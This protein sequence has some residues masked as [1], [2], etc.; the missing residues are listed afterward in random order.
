MEMPDMEDEA[1][2]RPF[3]FIVTGQYLAIHY[4]GGNFEIC[5]D[6]HTRGALFYLSYD[7][8]QIIHDRTYVA[9]LTDY[10]DYEG[11]VFYISKESQYLS[12]NG[13][14]SDSIEDAMKVQI[15]PEG[16]YGEAGR[17]S[18]P[19]IPDPIIDADNPISANGI[20]LYHPDKWFSL[21]RINGDSLWLGDAREFD[22]VLCFGT[23]PYSDGMPFQLSKHEGKTQ[24]RSDSGKYLTAMMEADLFEHLDEGCKQH[25][26]SS[27]CPR[28]MRWYTLGFSVEPQDFPKGLTSMFV[29]YDGLF[30]YKVAERIV[31]VDDIDDASIFQF[32]G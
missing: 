6:F 14:W 18:I 32:V 17:P 13:Q 12:Q 29:L 4:N 3:R 19:S 8:K 2:D 26:K 31:R 25:T 22:S 27:Q 16:D 5:R 15:E 1:F 30:Y 20:D 7:E 28:C 11:D 9:E 23:N 21:Y 10:P 24:I